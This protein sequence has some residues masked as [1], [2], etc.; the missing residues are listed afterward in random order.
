MHIAHQLG[1][2]AKTVTDSLIE[3]DFKFMFSPSICPRFGSL[4]IIARII[5]SKI[6][7]TPKM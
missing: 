5:A 2:L 3:T 1:I 6:P 7:A 4:I